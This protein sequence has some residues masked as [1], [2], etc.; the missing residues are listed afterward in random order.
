MSN[1]KNFVKNENS[2][3]RKENIER[4]ISN[5]F[6]FMEENY[7][8]FLSIIWIFCTIYVLFADSNTSYPT[9]IITINKVESDYVNKSE[10]DKISFIMKIESKDL[11][12]KKDIKLDSI[13]YRN[14]IQSFN[15]GKKMYEYIE[16]SYFYLICLIICFGIGIIVILS[17]I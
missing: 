4:N 17:Q 12:I 11:K 7:H 5:F 16:Y 2:K 3:L 8:I 14:Y 6:S 15:K 1:F 10:N 13:E 9:N